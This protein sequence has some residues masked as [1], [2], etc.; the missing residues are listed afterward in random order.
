MNKGLRPRR[1]V[2]NAMAHEIMLYGIVQMEGNGLDR[3]VEEVK[4]RM[5][6]YNVKPNMLIC[7]PQLLLYLATAPEEKIKYIEGGNLAVTRFEEGVEG[8]ETRNFR[9]LGVFQSTPYDVSEESDSV[10]MLQRNSQ[11]GEFYRMTPPAVWDGSKKLP[12]AYMDIMIYDEEADQLKHITF[13]QAFY[14]AIGGSKFKDILTLIDWK[15]A[16]KLPSFLAADT[17]GVRGADGSPVKTAYDLLKAPA[18]AGDDALDEALEKILPEH[19]VTCVEGGVWVP[20]CI[21]LARPFIEH[22]MMSC[23]VTV[24]GRDTGATLFGPAGALAVR[25]RPALCQLS[26]RRPPR[27]PSPS[28]GRHAGERQHVG[29]DDRGPLHVRRHLQP[30]SKPHRTALQSRDTTRLSRHRCHTKCVITKPQNVY[31]MRDV[32]C[33]GYVG[34]SNAR[35]FCNPKQEQLDENSF[36]AADKV[37]REQGRQR[38]RQEVNRALTQRLQYEEDDDGAWG[39]LLAFVSSYKESQVESRDQVISLSLRVLPWETGG[40]ATADKKH[41]PGGKDGYDHYKDIYQ[42]ESVHFG[43]DKRAAENQSFMSQGSTNNAICF[44]GPHRRYNPFASNFFELI[45]GQGHFGTDA[46]PG[47]RL[48]DDAHRPRMPHSARHHGT[49]VDPPPCSLCHQDCRW[50]RGESVSLKAARDSMVSLEVAAH[51]QLVFNTRGN[52]A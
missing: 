43:E 19:F 2:R 49:L 39:S 16:C 4:Q 27:T 48:P 9:G 17:E 36:G 47:V 15:N 42:L 11:V 23:I 51:S 28:V 6:R 31:V 26:V 18:G 52:I 41:F 38:F 37:Q 40:G 32:L 22:L 34:G 5:G 45:P 46:I 25:T 24:S 3:A 29:Q 13:K 10:Q 44:I 1:S 14:A 33:N 8:Y 21:T 7:P 50:R 20:I 35:F 12:S 30:M